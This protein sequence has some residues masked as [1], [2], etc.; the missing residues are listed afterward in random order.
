MR[1]SGFPTTAGKAA[2][3]LQDE[4]QKFCEL[5][6]VFVSTVF[7]FVNGYAEKF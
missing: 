6:Q 1:R 7:I 4:G 5:G 2:R 3:S